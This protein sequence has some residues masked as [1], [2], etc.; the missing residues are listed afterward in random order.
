M[1]RFFFSLIAVAVLAHFP[2]LVFSNQV[3]KSPIV[4]ASPPVVDGIDNDPAWEKA[5]AV[6]SHSRTA[7]KDVTIKTLRTRDMIY[8]LVK[9]PDK[10]ESRVQK[11]LHWNKE[12]GLYEL[13]P[14]REDCFVFKWNMGKEMVDLSVYSD[15]EYETD[16]WFWKA[17]RTD[18]AGYADDKR[19]IL[20]R[21]PS[22][23]SKEIKC[24]SGKSMYLS[25][26]SD[27]GKSAYSRNIPIEYKGDVVGQYT[28]RKPVGSRGDVKARGNWKEG[29]W[30]IEF[31][32]ALDTGNKDDV[33]FLAGNNYQFGIAISEI[34]GKAPNTKA[35]Q[36]LYGADD[37]SENLFLE[38]N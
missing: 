19:Q 18:P 21:K 17:C 31:S 33:Q 14:E 9:Y 36:P 5:E 8:F 30:T 38:M 3:L 35:Q 28:C 23:K 37:T 13:G 27:T 34:A 11:N 29:V 15:T 26:V 4:E 20:S 7:K 10:N 22:K 32:R 16:I 12:L 24:D 25:R 1:K 6:V 2:G